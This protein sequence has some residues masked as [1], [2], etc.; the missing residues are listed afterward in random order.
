MCCFFVNCT[1]ESLAPR[2][3]CGRAH[4]IAHGTPHRARFPSL[5]MLSI[6]KCEPHRTNTSSTSA[7]LIYRQGFTA[8]HVAAR[9]GQLSVLQTLLDAGTPVNFASKPALTTPLH[10]A[11]GFSR[12]ECVQELLRR[13]ADPNRKN[14]R[15]YTP[16]D[17]AGSLLPPT[18]DAAPDAPPDL[19]SSSSTDSDSYGGYGA[20][21]PRRNNEDEGI[22]GTREGTAADG[23]SMS[24]LSEKR[25]E[26]CARVR[27]ALHRA[28]AS[29]EPRHP[30]V[31]DCEKFAG[32]AEFRKN[33]SSSAGG[34]GSGASWVP[35][36]RARM[37]WREG[38]KR[39]GK[40]GGVSPVEEGR[41][42]SGRATKRSKRCSV[43]GSDR[44]KMEGRGFG[45]VRVG[46]CWRVVGSGL[47]GGN[48]AAVTSLMERL[49]KYDEKLMR[50]VIGFL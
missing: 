11:A 48:G 44:V 40:C 46:G 45:E 28:Q 20:G 25:T 16:L 47:G 33:G 24:S 12:V 36:E 38:Q 39:R 21:S 19:G 10:L 13:G 26:E 42:A 50:H 23:E 30:V 14:Q 32:S 37:D 34:V 49:C 43:N 27:D 31:L 8:L 18:A 17:L 6:A 1:A 3:N 7:L 9:C 2:R 29:S 5:K 35:E 22:R 4:E 15:G 41:T